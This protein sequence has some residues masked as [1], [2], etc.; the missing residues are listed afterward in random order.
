[1]SGGRE[2]YTQLQSK[3]E[4]CSFQDALK[5]S[6][7]NRVAFRSKNCHFVTFKILAKS[8]SRAP[9]ARCKDIFWATFS[10]SYE[11]LIPQDRKKGEEI[12]FA[13]KSVF[14]FL[15]SK[16]FLFQKLKKKNKS[17]FV[18]NC[19]MNSFIHSA[20]FRVPGSIWNI[21]GSFW[22]LKVG[23]VKVLKLKGFSNF[24]CNYE[25]LKNSPDVSLL[26][27]QPFLKI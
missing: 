3:V 10:K 8:F 22:V 26:V 21:I 23:Y 16:I 2:F 15:S 20:I 19:S 14:T 1:M 24:F 6:F 17:H 18:V 25:Y 11:T 4:F 13:E 7:K 27:F 12:F 5:K 9:W